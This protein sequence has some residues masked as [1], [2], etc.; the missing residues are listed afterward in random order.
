MREAG[1]IGGHIC[2]F[3]LLD[4]VVLVQLI[5]T[6]YAKG[7]HYH[8]LYYQFFAAKAKIIKFF[9]PLYI[10]LGSICFTCKNSKTQKN[11]TLTLTL[12]KM[13]CVPL[14]PALLAVTVLLFLSPMIAWRPWPHNKTKA[15][16]DSTFGDSKKFESSSSEFVHLKYRIGPVLT[17]NI[18]VHAI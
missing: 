5:S 12:T 10:N 14:Y 4:K 6:P 2:H 16:L 11:I 13:S 7:H 18:T 15:Q 3:V 8:W 1:I 9:F 17:A